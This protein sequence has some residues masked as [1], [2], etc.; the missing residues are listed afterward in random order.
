V[1][2]A[3]QEALEASQQ[4][5]LEEAREDEEFRRRA[6]LRR[7][8]WEEEFQKID[9]ARN[10]SVVGSVVRVLSGLLGFNSNK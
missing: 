1:L 4:Q 6:A 3:R 8:E 10:N 7:A 9:N 5:D 2:K